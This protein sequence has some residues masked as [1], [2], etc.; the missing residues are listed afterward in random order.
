M[1]ANKRRNNS[2]SKEKKKENKSEKSKKKLNKKMQY[3]LYNEITKEVKIIRAEYNTPYTINYLGSDFRVSARDYYEKKELTWK[4]KNYR[5]TKDKPINKKNFC[6]G[7]IKGYKNLITDDNSWKYYLTEDHSDI[8]KKLKQSKNSEKEINEDIQ[9]DNIDIQK[10]KEN[11]SDD[12]NETNKKSFKDMHFNSVKE[13]DS[14]VLEECKQNKEYLSTNQN[15]IKSFKEIYTNNNL[16]LKENH[17][18]YLYKKYKK[19]CFPETLDEIYEYSNFIND[20]GYFCRNCSIITLCN[21]ENK[22]FNHKQMIFFTDDNIKRIIASENLLIDA[23]FTYPKS[24]YQTLIIMFY[25]PIYL[26][27]F[28]GI[29]VVM[30]NKY[31]EGYLEVFKYI[32]YYIYK[33]VKNNF[34]KIKWKTFTTDFEESLFKAFKDTFDFS[35]DIKHNGCFF[36]YLKN[37]RKYLIKNGFGCKEKKNNYQY[38]IN[39]CYKLPFIENINKNIVKSINNIC[40]KDKIYKDFNK[41]FINQWSEYFNNKSLC[42]KDIDKKFRTNNSLENFNRIFKTKMGNKGEIELVKYVDNLIDITKDQ[43]NYFLK[44]IKRPHKSISNN[45]I[46]KDNKK[47]INEETETSD[48]DIF[49]ELESSSDIIN[50]DSISEEKDE[51]QNNEIEK[52]KD[53]NDINEQLFLSNYQLSCSFDSFLSIFINTIYPAIIKNQNEENE[54]NLKKNKKYKYYIKF[55]ETLNQKNIIEQMTFYD[56]YE[57]FNNDNKLDLFELDEE[58]EKYDLLPIVINYRNLY[59]NKLFCIIYSIKH[60]C[61]GKCKFKNQLIENNLMSSPYIDI[62]LQA[63]LDNLSNNIQELFQN[64]IYI[65]L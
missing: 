38:L 62:P 52:E 46:K 43:I 65:N 61:T 21:N 18:N 28:P 34:N 35:N 17:L 39:E 49:E 63:Y 32:K 58:I 30:N 29:F 6:D 59:N 13:L 12:S 54:I 44:E 9:T 25:D 33:E 19:Y 15:F 27:M 8:C 57:E 16:E 26:K 31:Y 36:H 48:N 56:I 60:F 20:L 37:I 4:C 50:K 24:F 2:N 3:L 42:L 1:K 41:Y 5:R 11:S 51:L 23:T 45:K 7:T 53:I 14:Y 22:L 10:K 40:K 64:Y 55:I 47:N